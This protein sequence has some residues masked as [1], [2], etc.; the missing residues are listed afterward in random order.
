[1]LDLRGGGGSLEGEFPGLS[2]GARPRNGPLLRA[3]SEKVPV[4]GNLHNS[5][6]KR[7][8]SGRITVKK[9]LPPVAELQKET[10]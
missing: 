3:K 10:R 9:Q 7:D 6:R 4:G 8:E 5:P 2:S 1:M